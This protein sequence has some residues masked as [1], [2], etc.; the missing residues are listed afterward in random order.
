[1]EQILW[2]TRRTLGTRSVNMRAME[3][4]CAVVVLFSL[5]IA[6]N[7]EIYIV[8]VI[9]EPVISYKGGVP[10]FEATA[11]ESDETIDVTRYRLVFTLN[12]A[13][14]SVFKSWMRLLSSIYLVGLLQVV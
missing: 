2:D 7:A 12:F 3:L 13:I 14:A 9:G 8:T 10:G 6:G 4:G 5:L 1:M 11:V